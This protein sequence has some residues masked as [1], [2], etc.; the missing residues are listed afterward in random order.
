MSRQ[1]SVIT[2]GYFPSDNLEK[3]AI[4]R[5]PLTSEK[6]KKNKIGN[7]I[8]VVLIKKKKQALVGTD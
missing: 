3:L 7:S 4:E 8:I 1:P 2:K 6:K 5:Q